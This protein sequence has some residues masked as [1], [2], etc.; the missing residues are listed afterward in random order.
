[1]VRNVRIFSEMLAVEFKWLSTWSLFILVDGEMES[2]KLL[3]KE[4]H[5]R[6]SGEHRSDD[7]VRCSDSE[8]VS[9]SVAVRHIFG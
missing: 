8:L 6:W 7:G 5:G 4:G 2:E 1:M 3:V 9:H